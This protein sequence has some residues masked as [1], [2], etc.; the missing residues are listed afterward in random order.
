[1]FTTEQL[2]RNFFTERGRGFH[3]WFS[4]S[5]GSGEGAAFILY[6]P[7]AA[8]S[9]LF[10]TLLVT[11]IA[12]SCDDQP[13]SITLGWSDD[14]A[15][16]SITNVLTSGNHASSL[17]DGSTDSVTELAVQEQNALSVAVNANFFAERLGAD[18]PGLTLDLEYPLILPPGRGLVAVYDDAPAT[19]ADNCVFAWWR[20]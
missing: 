2:P 5:N 17:L 6:N 4:R 11:K 13:A 20:V 19:R 12:C 10:K 9:A 18:Q 3:G 8:G 1:M 15:L 7:L 16:E 14:S